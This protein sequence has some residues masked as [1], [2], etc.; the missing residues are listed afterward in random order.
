VKNLLILKSEHLDS[1]FFQELC[2][3]VVPLD[4]EQ[5][6]M[7][8]PVQFDNDATFRT[9]KVDNVRTYTVLPTELLPIDL[10]LPQAGPE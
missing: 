9:I 2:S 3:S 7:Y 1:K 5:P 8:G 4:S 6:R 10:A